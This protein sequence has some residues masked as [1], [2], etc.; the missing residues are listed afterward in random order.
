MLA[1]LGVSLFNTPEEQLL[2][3]SPE[4]KRYDITLRNIEVKK[5]PKAT[6][7]KNLVNL[8]LENVVVNGRRVT[9]EEE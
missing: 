9:K 4:A 2:A 7:M 6:Q 5:A 1:T 3:N 8:K